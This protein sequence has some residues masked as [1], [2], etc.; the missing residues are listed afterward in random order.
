M[1]KRGFNAKGRQVVETVQDDS[2]TKQVRPSIAI[3]CC[4][5]MLTARST[6]S[7]IQIKLD[8]PSAEYGGE[9]SANALVLPSKKRDSKVKKAPDATNVTR[10]L[11]KKKRKQLEKIVDRK[12]KKEGVS[13][14]TTGSCYQSC[15]PTAYI[16]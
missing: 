7:A 15:T 14:T 4:V 12:Q 13:S 8:F 11:S 2:T 10:I 16:S 9:D 3:T 6:R 1:G 5:V